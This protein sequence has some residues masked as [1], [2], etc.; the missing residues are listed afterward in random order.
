MSSPFFVYWRF[1]SVTTPPT[2]RTEP[3]AIGA[4]ASGVA[5]AARVAQLGQRAVGVPARAS[6]R[7]PISGWS[8]T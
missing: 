3:S 8:L 7:G 4:A 6:P 2:E 1:S 5:R